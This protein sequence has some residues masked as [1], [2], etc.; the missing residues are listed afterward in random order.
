VLESIIMQ[1]VPTQSEVA[2]AMAALTQAMAGI[3]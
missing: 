1:E 3:Y 2:S